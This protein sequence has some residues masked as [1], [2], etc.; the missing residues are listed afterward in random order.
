M[1]RGTGKAVLVAV[2]MCFVENTLSDH[3]G[4]RPLS[5]VIFCII[6]SC[7]M[8]GMYH[9][10]HDVP[11]VSPTWC[12]VYITSCMMC[13]MYHLHD[14][15][16]VSPPTCCSV[17]ILV[18]SYRPILKHFIHAT[19]IHPERVLNSLWLSVRLYASSNSRT[20]ERIVMKFDITEG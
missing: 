1:C 18:P 4:W 12:A 10:L 9:L 8:C 15:R 11:Y 2:C 5:A 17:C 20:A 13:G 3:Q 14:V 16:Y 7:M 19:Y 6:T